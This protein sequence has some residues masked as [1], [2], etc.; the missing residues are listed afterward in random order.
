[1][2]PIFKPEWKKDFE[3]KIHYHFLFGTLRSLF[4]E[5]SQAQHLKKCPEF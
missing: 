5:T 1:M 4:E 2:S 3:K